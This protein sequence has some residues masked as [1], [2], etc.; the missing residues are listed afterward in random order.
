MTIKLYDLV[1]ANDRRYSQ[2]S[3]RV[4]FALRHKN[5]E[6][7]IVS[8]LLIDKDA[9]AFSGG[10]TLPVLV[11]GE[12]V[13]RDSWEIAC[14]LE[15]AYPDRPSLFGGPVGRGLARVINAWAD[16]ALNVAIAPLIARDVLD[17]AH[18]DDRDHLRAT[19]EQLFKRPVEEVQTNREKGLRG[20]YHTLDPLRSTLR[21]GQ[22][23]MSGDGPAMPDYIVFSVFQWARVAS[24]FRLIE[25]DDPVH[26]WRERMLDL[27]DGYARTT[28][29]FPLG[30]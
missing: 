21:T 23:F 1:G 10:T 5:L 17:I 26:A 18:P 15:D 30:L 3:W 6:P 13:V 9:I 25:A 4:K 11:D 19:M 22:P 2:F 12:T 16:R 14:Y 24:S 27:H 8:V 29:A 20:L 28:L 7:E